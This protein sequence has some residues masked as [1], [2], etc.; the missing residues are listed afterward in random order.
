MSLEGGSPGARHV[1]RRTRPVGL[2]NVG[3]PV[4]RT[5]RL[6][7]RASWCAFQHTA[8]SVFQVPHDAFRRPTDSRHG[9]A[10]VLRRDRPGFRTARLTTDTTRISNPP[11]LSAGR[12]HLEPPCASRHGRSGSLQPVDAFRRR[13]LLS[14]LRTACT[15]LRTPLLVALDTPL[16]VAGSPEGPA[17][18]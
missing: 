11:C 9:P 1:L 16:G 2:E 8:I 18:R 12:G 15:V 4:Q 6:G 13:G 5:T 7:L 3:T 17:D 10:Q 14:K